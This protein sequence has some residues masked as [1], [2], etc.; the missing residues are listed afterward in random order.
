MISSVLRVGVV[1]LA[2]LA[3]ASVSLAEEN[4]YGAGKGGIGGQLGAG[5]V[6]GSGDYS[7]G[8]Q[9]RFSFSGHLRY[10]MTKSWRWQ[11]SPGLTWAG[12]DAKEKAPFQ[13]LNF[14]TDST[15]AEHLSVMVPVSFQI[16][17][18]VHRGPWI[19]YGGA[20][21]GVYR[22]WVE[23]QRKVLKDPTTFVL[24]RGAYAGFTAQVG[25]ERFLKALTTTSIE[26]SLDYNQAFAKR[27]EQFPNGYNDS[28]SAMGLRIGVNYYFTP[29]QPKKQTEIPSSAPKKP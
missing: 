14:P 15:K 27:D 6:V 5:R 7:T 25:F 13:D 1:A 2:M 24:H 22:V 11:F 9:V 16:Q 20:G 17:Y 12:Y 10:A 21:P 18:T 26:G 29:K 19:Y 8:A 3:A 28:M 23:N 4:S